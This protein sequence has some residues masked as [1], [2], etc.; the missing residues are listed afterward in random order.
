MHVA[1]SA[2]TG[3][4]QRPHGTGLVSDTPYKCTSSNIFCVRSVVTAKCLLMRLG[5]CFASNTNLSCPLFKLQVIHQTHSDELTG[6]LA[7]SCTEAALV[8]SVMW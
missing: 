8:S 6:W 3:T 7:T 2:R 4:V 5:I 1:F